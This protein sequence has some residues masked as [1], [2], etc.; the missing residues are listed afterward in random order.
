MDPRLLRLVSDRRFRCFVEIL[1][2]RRCKE[3]D[4]DVDRL[5]GGDRDE[6]EKVYKLIPEFDAVRRQYGY[7]VVGRLVELVNKVRSS[8]VSDMAEAFAVVMSVMFGVNVSRDDASKIGR[9]IDALN[10]LKVGDGGI[11][12]D[13]VCLDAVDVPEEFKN[14]IRMVAV[15]NMLPAWL[16]RD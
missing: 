7:D 16:G 10:C 14:Q 11:E 3:L 12:V 9:I 6:V 8:N 5:L 15:A 13:D 4:V 2:G 1:K